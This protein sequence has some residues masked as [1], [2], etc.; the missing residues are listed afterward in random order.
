MKIRNILAMNPKIYSESLLEAVE[1]LLGSLPT[2]AD[3]D[4]KD[5]ACDYL[6]DAPI[7]H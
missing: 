5:S 2:V 3:L 7:M 6:M 1:A 4:Q